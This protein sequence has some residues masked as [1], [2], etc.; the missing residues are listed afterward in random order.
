[1]ITPSLR[2][3]CSAVEVLHK[4]FIRSNQWRVT[5][6]CDHIRLVLSSEFRNDLMCGIDLFVGWPRP[7]C[8]LDN[9]RQI[10]HIVGVRQ[11][12]HMKSIRQK[13]VV[14]ICNACYTLPDTAG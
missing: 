12:D 14:L 9:A 4:W 5:W 13:R 6:I 8:V 1:M 10:A 2:Q 11:V 7:L 3:P